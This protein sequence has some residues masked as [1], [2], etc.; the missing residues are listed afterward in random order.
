[1]SC[2]DDMQKSC[3]TAAWFRCLRWCTEVLA[4]RST[5]AV[6]NMLSWLAFTALQAKQE[7][8]QQKAQEDAKRRHEAT[9]KREEEAAQRRYFAVDKESRPV[10]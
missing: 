1:M 4:T 3:A 8:E 6:C 5:T 10:H 2:K 9:R 7:E